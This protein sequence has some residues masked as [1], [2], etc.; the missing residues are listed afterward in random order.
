[1]TNTRR[2]VGQWFKYQTWCRFWG[3]KAPEKTTWW[4]EG[5][6]LHVTQSRNGTLTPATPG[7]VCENCGGPL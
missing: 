6:T 4:H 2:T 5:P 1:M 3:C 7:V